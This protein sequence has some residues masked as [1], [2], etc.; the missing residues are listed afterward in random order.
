MTARRERVL[1]IAHGHPDL[2]IGGG[3]VAA[4]DSFRTLRASPGVEAA[5]FLARAGRDDGP[6]SGAITRHAEGE[7]L[8]DQD[9]ADWHL[10]RAAHAPSAWLG[11]ADLLDALQPTVVHVHHVV[12]L[13]LEMLRAIRRHRPQARLVMTLH[14]YLALCRNDGQMVRRGTLAPCSRAHP[15]DCHRCFPEHPPE[16]FWLRRRW[17]Q[18]HY[19]MVDA[20]VAP[21]R[22]LRDRYV[23]WGLPPERV[24]VIENGQP[25]EPVAA[26]RV[27]SPGEGRGRI[28][29]FGQINAYKG[30]DRLLEAIAA[31]PAPS[32]G[33]LVLEV[34]G[35]KL[36]R[37]PAELRARIEA[38]AA[39]LIAE[40]AVAWRGPYAPADLR[41][42]M[43]GV[44][45]VAVPSVWWENSPLVIQEAFRCGR[46][47]LCSGLGGMAEKV[48]HDVDGL[49]LPP[50][51]IPA[52]GATLSMLAAERDGATWERLR[53]GIRK[54]LTHE[55]MARALL[56]LYDGLPARAPEMA[57]VVPLV[58]R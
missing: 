13:G 1:V 57:D 34:H 37:Q 7:Y 18:H 11:F 29:F 36:E 32:R 12:H 41:A 31:R 43:A 5:W 40:G 20:F 26:P 15:E 22:F 54:P 52:W 19:A 56:A 58:R 2:A 42:R 9:V 16:D 17:L 6:P 3:E 4:H 28:G 51:D 38:L 47:V 49:H 25:D 35:A 10:L 23:A 53:R 45:W 33:G 48:R 14:E 39:P 21:S 55:A 24:V 50:G 44:D 30:L 27:A 46:P 8:W